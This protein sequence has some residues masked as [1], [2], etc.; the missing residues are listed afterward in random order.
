[1][2]KPVARKGKCPDCRREYVVKPDGR[3]PNHD[4][5][6][7]KRRCMGSRT[8]VAKDRTL[9]STDTSAREARVLSRKRK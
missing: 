7:L 6:G 9:M 4:R 8:M 3:L 1:M 5:R 2:K